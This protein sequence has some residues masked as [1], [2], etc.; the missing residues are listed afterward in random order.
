MTDNR[1]TDAPSL[2]ARLRWRW[3]WGVTAVL[4]LSFPLS[5]V[6]YGPLSM[7]AVIL[8]VAGIA[9]WVFSSKEPAKEGALSLLIYGAAMLP[10]LTIVMAIALWMTRNQ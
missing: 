10:A 2:G 8:I 5:V 7:S 6:L 9:G 1:K 4:V 3:S